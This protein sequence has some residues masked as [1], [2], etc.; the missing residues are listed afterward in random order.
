MKQEHQQSRL[1]KIAKFFYSKEDG[2]VL[3][4]TPKSWGLIFAFYLVAYAFLAGFFVG[5]ISVFMYG[6]VSNDIPS[7][8][9]KQSLLS[10]S[11]GVVFAPRVTT[12]T[13]FL[14]FT[15]F[16][17]SINAPYIEGVRR[18]LS[19]YEAS[20]L[21]TVCPDGAAA[22]T[23]PEQPCQFPLVS[24]GPCANPEASL[25]AGLPCIYLRLNKV[26]GWLPDLANV[27][28]FPE[29]AINCYGQN[30]IAKFQLGQP[31]YFP[32]LVAPDGEK[33]A[34]IPSTYF[35]FIGQ[36]GYQTPLAAVRFPNIMKNTVVLVECKV[37][38]LAGVDSEVL[39]EI[40]VDGRKSLV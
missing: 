22:L 36:P 1:R 2:T 9:G 13:A 35:P 17:S 18:L 19:R 32:Q 4:R 8:T 40:A 28:V 38:G 11:P 3:G 26:F 16:P 25:K 33:Y 39:F 30:E 20:N 10:L 5:M 27:T 37:Y 31:E 7:L 12:T 23:F 24:L 21:T 14:Q 6:Y 29:A 34:K 15:T